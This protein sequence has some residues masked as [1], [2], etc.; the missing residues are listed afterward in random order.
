MRR[1]MLG[2]ILCSGL[3]GGGVLLAADGNPAHTAEDIRQALFNAQVALMAGDAENAARA[4][5][6]AEGL[7]QTV[8][9]PAFAAD[10]PEIDAQ[11][12]ALFE[13]AALAESVAAFA[14]ARSQIWTGLL[15]GSGQV[16]FAAVA[17]DDSATAALWLPLR[18]FRVSTRF[19]RPGADATLAIRALAEGR[20][21]RDEAAAAVEADLWDTYQAQLN[22]SL[23]DAD[24]AQQ[25]GFALRRAE[26]AALAQGYFAILAPAYETQRSQADA[27]ALQNQFTAMV[28][29][30]VSGRDDAFAQARTQ[31]DMAL[32]GFR[33]APLSQEELARRA[34][35]LTRFV[36]LVP[37]EYARGVRNGIVTNDIE[38]QEALTFHEGAVSA[39]QDLQSALTQIDA[40]ATNQL[41]QLLPQAL[42]QI[43][44]TVEPADLQ[45]TID[46]INALLAEVIPAEWQTGGGASDVDVILSVLDQV[47]KS[48][49]QD[50]YTLA[51]SARLEAYALL[52]LGVEQRLRGF[53]PELAVEIESLFWQGTTDQP[54]LAVLL[55]SKAPLGDVR[56]S[57]AKL[58]TT[59]DEARL[60]LGSSQSAPAAVT[61]NAAVIVFREGLEAV[62]ILASLLASLRTIEQRRFRRP[63]IVGAALAFGATVVTWVIATN[64][65]NVLLPLGEKLEAIVSL[66]A[67]GVLLLITNWFFHKAYWVG[68]MANFHARKRELVSGVVTIAI[69]QTIGLVLLGFTSIYREGFETVLFL[70]SLVLEA[71]T[72][73][74]LQGVALGLLGTAVVGLITFALQV[75]LPYKKMLIVTGVLIG[76][77][78]LTMVGHTVHVMQSIG[79]LPITPISGLFIPYWMG[80]WFG[81]F[82]TWQGVILQFAAAA[83]VIGS[84]F[85]AE[86]QNQRQR[87]RAQQPVEAGQVM[88]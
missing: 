26:E 15:N 85:L 11:V 12:Q 13:Q 81:L 10:A 50:D 78:L 19:S 16:V 17:A 20:L 70:Q 44:T 47:E 60:L 48:A 67:I 52:E 31:I 72:G 88:L 76:G 56:A 73:I 18:D 6:E 59:F 33:A 35:Q 32:A 9:S 36:A 49:A 84:Y 37:V 87:I 61:G 65:L 43:R 29:A 45:A 42:E 4:V 64:L 23:V 24:E 1:M 8:L 5:E 2:L 14:A 80:Q 79:W 63:L 21:N 66:I 58:E 82:A 86:H 34:G 38:V 46:Q 51:E 41:A 62:L 75:R 30:A 7:Y 54:G 68:W 40:E 71:G 53:A 27:E 57:L 74:V 83:F 55:V 25:H 28:D 77:V 69:S 3:L 22:T 39:F